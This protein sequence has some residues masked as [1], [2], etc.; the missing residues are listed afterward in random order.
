MKT[1]I[2]TAVISVAGLGT[3]M[4][5][6]TE[7]VPKF[8][9]PV[10]AGDQARPVIDYVIDECLGA[11]VTNLIFVVSDGG[12]AVLRGYLGPVSQVRAEQL[13]AQVARDPKKQLQLDKELTRRAAF[14]GIDIT[15]V[16]QPVG[17]YGTAVPLSLVRPL[18]QERGIDYCIFI[19]GD[20]FLWRPDGR[21]EWADALEN[22]DGHRSI[23]MGDDVAL[24]DASRYGILQ[25]TDDGNLVRIVEKPPADQVP[26]NPTRNISRYLIGPGLWPFIDAEMRRNPEANQPEHYVTD[27]INNAVA[28]GETF[29]IHR[30]T[31]TYLDCGTPRSALAAGIYITGKLD[32]HQALATANTQV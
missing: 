8:M 11:G 22:W 25:G 7:G 17:P 26:K 3:R 29:K 31:S 13:T 16:E 27:A 9:S 24:E 28:A 15:Y 14:A 12:E 10:Y 4:G 19:T 6:F 21:S 32:K 30:I 2:T 5:T 1:P 20:D 23:I 18:L